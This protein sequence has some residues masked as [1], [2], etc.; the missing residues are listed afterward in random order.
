MKAL[1][2][3]WLKTIGTQKAFSL[4]VAQMEAYSIYSTVHIEVIG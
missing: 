4:G 2:L 3:W 1:A